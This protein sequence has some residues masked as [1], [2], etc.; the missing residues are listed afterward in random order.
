MKPILLPLLLLPGLALAND[1]KHED[2]RQLALDLD[3]V[4][5][6]RFEVNSHDLRLDGVPDESVAP[7]QIRACASD[8]DYLSQL[9]VEAQR[10]GDTL[11]VTIERRG[12][13]SGLFFSPTYANLEVQARLPAGLAYDVEVGSGDAEVAGVASLVADVGS[14]DLE[15]R[16]ISGE[17]RAE[18][19]SGDLDFDDIGSLDLRSV[20]S[21]DLD[22]RRV[23]GD[24]QIGSLGSGDI[25][26]DG[27]AGSV[28]VRRIGSGDLD[29]HDVAG[30][31]VVE[32]LGSGDV[33]HGRVLGAVNV[34]K[35]D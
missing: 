20:G 27:V 12:K 4:S 22:A 24:V 30:D 23:R 10:S 13:S 34:P 8:P 3:G 17:V 19:G 7:L 1:C 25:D 33:D 21:G 16:R 18:V 2:T 9:V 32:R 31:L 11:R 5:L 26:L 28:R 14:G 29:V 15:A 6:V 35:D